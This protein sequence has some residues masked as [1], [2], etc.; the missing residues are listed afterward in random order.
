MSFHGVWGIIKVFS[1]A[2]SVYHIRTAG[3]AQLI[4]VM[5]LEKSLIFTSHRWFLTAQL[6][7]VGRGDLIFGL[8]QSLLV[9]MFSGCDVQHPGFQTDAI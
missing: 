6:T 1:A 4:K 2:I 7:Y 8:H 5:R 3:P 9:S